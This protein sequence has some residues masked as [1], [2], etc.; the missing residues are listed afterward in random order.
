MELDSGSVVDSE[1]E[2]LPT[3]EPGTGEEEADFSMANLAKEG[4]T[5]VCVCVCVCVCVGGGGGGFQSIS[6]DSYCVHVY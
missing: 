1:S 4:V 3:E 6:D 2:A 5:E